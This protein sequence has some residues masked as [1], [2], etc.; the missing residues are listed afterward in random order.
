MPGYLPFAGAL[1]LPAFVCDNCG[2]WQRHFAEPPSCP[3]CR[4]ARHVVP[5]DGWRFRGVAEAQGAFPCHWAE[6]EPGVWRFW[7][8]P[9]SGIGPSAYLITT[10][11][12]NM[13]FEG[14][15]VFSEAALD[16]IAALGGMAVL[17]ASHPHSYA[18]LPQLQDRFDP[19]L[20][21]P[22]ADFVWSAALQVSWPYDDA[23][24]PLPG[25][26]LHRTA[27]HFDGHAVLYD[28]ARKILFCGD[29]LKFELDP[30]DPR[31]ALTISAHKAFVRGVPLTPAELRRYRAVF[32]RLDFV[33]TWTPFEQAANVGRRE[34]LALID[35]MLAGR[36]HASPVPLSDL[37]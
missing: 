11:G 1:D 9:V 14:C 24:E 4:D 15:S 5:Q 16:R 3:L 10:P 17:S 23:L 30:A 6:V 22:A 19:E 21:L 33:Q 34:V 2:F 32:E 36:P 25:L 18:A 31:R 27:G 7:N 20:A 37:A 12:G 13:G 26:E 28:R 35:A 29:A 8:D